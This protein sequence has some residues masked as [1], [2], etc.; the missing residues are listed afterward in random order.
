MCQEVEHIGNMIKSEQN[1]MLSVTHT[2]TLQTRAYIKILAFRE[3]EEVIYEL[4]ERYEERLLGHTNP[5]ALKYS[6]I[7]ENQAARISQIIDKLYYP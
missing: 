5:L 6:V 3:I 7:E 2:G 4:A 1:F